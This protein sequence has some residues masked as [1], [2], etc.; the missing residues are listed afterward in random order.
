[1]LAARV[2]AAT[3]RRNDGRAAT[4]LA[5]VCAMSEPNRP[6]V[7]V[8]DDDDR[9]RELLRVLLDFEGYRVLMAANGPDALAIVAGEPVD[10]V[11]LDFI[12]PGMGGEEVCRHIRALGLRHRLPIVCLSGMDDPAA[13]QSATAAGADEFIAKP[14]DRV[15]LRQRVARL[16]TA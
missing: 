1:M 8:V 12:M 3:I 10:V 5:G 15:D 9:S 7:L 11:V 6:V 13:R 14:F 2:P 16:L 4:V